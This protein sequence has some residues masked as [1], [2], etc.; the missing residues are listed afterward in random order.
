MASR[1]PV[2]AIHKGGPRKIYGVYMRSL[3]TYKITLSITEIGKNVKQNLEKK[4]VS[5]NEGKCIVEGFVKPNSVKIISYSSGKVMGDRVE[6]TTVFECMISCPVEGM[7]IESSAKTI[8]KAGIHA[9]VED[10][11][12]TIP[13]T[14]FIARDHHHLDAEFNVIKEG[15]KVTVKVIGIRYEL[16]DPHICIIARLDNTRMHKDKRG[17][18]APDIYG[19]VDDE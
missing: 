12:G 18:G 1:K 7:I 11:D 17:G 16:N 4:L 2:A 8:T 10:E 13:I 19:L 15:D 6:F 3:L 9:Q 14:V 5:K